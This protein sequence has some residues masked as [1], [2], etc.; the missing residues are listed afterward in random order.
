VERAGNFHAWLHVTADADGKVRTAVV[1]PGSILPLDTVDS[2]ERASVSRY[3]LRGGSLRVSD[4]KE[5]E[6]LDA[7]MTLPLKNDLDDPRTFHLE[8]RFPR[9]VN[10]QIVPRE[11][12]VDLAPG[13]AKEME[14]RISSAAAPAPTDRLPHL[15]V[16]SKTTL[17]TGV[18]SR[19]EEAQY[20]QTLALAEENPETYATRIELDAP[21]TFTARYRLYVPPEAR[22][23]QRQGN[24]RIDGVFDEPDWQTAPVIDSFS[25][26]DG[27]TPE[28]KTTVRLLYDDD[29]LYV[30]AWMEEPDPQGLVAKASGDIPLTW[31]DDDLELFFDTAQSQRDYTRL[32][33]NAAGT[34]F[35][36]LPRDVENK[37]FQS[38]YESAIHVGEDHWAIEMHIPWKEMSAEG[39]ARPGDRWNINIGRHRPRSAMSTQQWAGSLYQP[40]MYGVL[41]FE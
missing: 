34:R 25:T 36:S 8:W 7:A 40:P 23:P 4:W 10:I 1:K 6:P 17:R 19:A 30:A 3:L 35:N 14:Y 18:V 39:P 13:E 33:Q 11:T 38:A 9:G 21:V 16:N 2:A 41:V 26:P 12:W 15:E 37:Y 24:I 28:T 31:N 27:E 22:A 29:G 20:R 32:F 5:G